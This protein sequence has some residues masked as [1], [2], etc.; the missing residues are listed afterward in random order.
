[1]SETRSATVP[2]TVDGSRATA[3]R[4]SS[5]PLATL[6]RAYAAPIAAF[7][8]LLVIG[9]VS[10]R[11]FGGTIPVIG[12]GG[13]TTDTTTGDGAVLTPARTPSPSAP[14]V[15]NKDISIDGNLVFV[16]AGNLWIQTGTDIRQLTNTGRDS[17]PAWSGDGKWVYFVDTR[18]QFTYFPDPQTGK[19]SYYDLRYPVLTRIHPDGTGREAV[20]SGFYRTGPGK[21]WFYFLNTPAVS[22][23]GKTVAVGSDAP[24]PRSNN[25]VIQLLDVARGRMT[26]PKL[27][28]TGVLGH[29]DPSW[30]PDGRY[31][32]YVKNENQG[33][34]VIWRYDT[35]TKRAVALT[36]G[37]YTKPVY[38]P[39]GRFL[40]AVKT[41]T[42][43]T[44]VVLLDART[45]SELLRV[46]TDGRS[47][48]PA[49]SPDG[50]RLAY[51]VLAASGLTTDVDIVKI[52]TGPNGAP[53]LDGDPTALTKSSGLDGDSRP[54]W[55]GPAAAPAPTA[56]ASPGASAAPSGPVAGGGATPP[57]GPAG[58][59]AP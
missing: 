23:N 25:V 8:G 56:S 20:L 18:E 46:T 6:L 22:P 31:L 33:G 41:N 58:S 10:L 15:I 27:P 17:Q 26:N 32:V 28:Q 9:L 14:P 57:A 40:A 16:K 12:K 49:W 34:P 50:S 53:A 21:G 35:T 3:S 4:G 19:S 52:A 37:G 5:G 55:W 45:G 38:S 54:A 44:N 29:Q 7:V 47:W 59:S 42:I 43:G 11:L 24:D 36:N 2:P 30:S 51:L 39:D 48:G 1:V 13:D